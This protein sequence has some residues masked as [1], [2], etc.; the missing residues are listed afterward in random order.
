MGRTL[1]ERLK[2]REK[3]VV[4]V[5]L[6]EN[7]KTGEL[8]SKSR[9]NGV[10]LDSS[11][12]DMFGA[13]MAQPDEMV[14]VILRNVTRLPLEELDRLTTE[15]HP[16]DAKMFTA[17]L[18]TTQLRGAEAAEE[19]RR[20]FVEKF[21]ERAIPAEMPEALTAAG[22]LTVFELARL[23]SG[24]ELSN[25]ELRRLIAQGALRIDGV[26]HRDASVRAAIPPGGVAVS[27]GR[28]RWLR[29]RRG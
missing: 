13:V 19:A 26:A 24:P 6:M 21:Q 17:Q 27:I 28:R 18:V 20:L 2:G 11:A 9:G 1:L 3:F 14:P 10:F 29:V 12:E 22:E 25:S 23:C 7:P 4:A 16:R 5:N 8:M 15:T